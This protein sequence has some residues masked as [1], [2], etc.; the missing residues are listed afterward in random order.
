MRCNCKST[1]YPFLSKA[2]NE[3]AK[4]IDGFGMLI[5]Q[6]VIGIEYWTGISANIRSNER[7]T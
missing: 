3:G 7:L 2:K 6:G 4:T 5:N 1:K